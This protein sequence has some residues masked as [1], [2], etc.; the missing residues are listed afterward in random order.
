VQ[1]DDPPHQAEPD[2]EPALRAAGVGVDLFEHLEHTFEHFCR[3][4]GAVVADPKPRLVSVAPQR[5]PDAA[6]G[7]GVLG[8]VVDQVGTTCAS[9]TGSPSTIRPSL[10]IVGSW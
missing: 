8:G 4:P 1:L 2:A 7:R 6:A 5:E 9:R 3:D 10:G